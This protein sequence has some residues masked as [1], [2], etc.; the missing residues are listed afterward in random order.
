MHAST[1]SRVPEDADSMGAISVGRAVSLV[2]ELR[3]E[4]AADPD[5]SGEERSLLE[6][7][8]SATAAAQQ[9]IGVGGSVVMDEDEAVGAGLEAA[10][11]DTD[12]MDTLGRLVSRLRQR[13]GERRV[14]AIQAMHGAVMAVAGLEPSYEDGPRQVGL[15]ATR[16]L[17]RGHAVLREAALAFAPPVSH[18]K[19]LVASTGA[20][21]PAPSGGSMCPWCLGD[22]NDDGGPCPESLSGRSCR[23]DLP[24]FSPELRAALE[25]LVDES[26]GGAA[27]LPLLVGRLALMMAGRV[28]KPLGALETAPLGGHI[29]DGEDAAA[30]DAAAPEGPP[31]ADQAEHGL[32][33]DTWRELATLSPLGAMLG[34]APGAALPSEVVGA[35]GGG[36][37]SLRAALGC[38]QALPGDAWPAEA[39]PFL[40][41]EAALVS[42]ALRLAGVPPAVEGQEGSQWTELDH[43]A[44]AGV[45]RLSAFDFATPLPRPT[46]RLPTV[47]PAM[48]GPLEPDTVEGR[49]TGPADRQRDNE[50]ALTATSRRLGRALFPATVSLL[51]HSCRPNCAL[52][53]EAGPVAK[54]VALTDV[55]PGQ[56]LTISYIDAERMSE[57][58]R[59]RRLQLHHAF[60]C[61]C[62]GECDL[63]PAEQAAAGQEALASAVP[64]GTTVQ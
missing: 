2:E 32:P 15:R 60:S 54:L 30:D 26:R 18:V 63:G 5:T 33:P 44:V 46:V 43:L 9:E 61:S 64:A 21:T 39:R 59:Y 19:D 36:R 12:E 57:Q 58:E 3:E 37:M 50:E 27:L 6:R 53:F 7:L 17:G 23:A 51:N 31:T 29:D 25:V 13:R 22:R 56:E 24:V 4:A 42:D 62:G 11:L 34:F 28:E 41:K 35:G 14:E 10:D 40:A 38:L 16:F 1:Q 45:A 20:G 49:P 47:S 52:V 55:L 8:A 48:G